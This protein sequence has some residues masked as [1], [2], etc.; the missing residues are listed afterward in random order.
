MFSSH[1]LTAWDADGAVQQMYDVLN[2]LVNVCVEAGDILI[3]G[4]DFNACIGSIDCDDLT[5]L[6]HVG[7]IGMG[8]RNARG[9]M[10][11][12]SILQNKFYVSKSR[13]KSYG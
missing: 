8:Q 13:E 3:V 5:F 6:Q 4:G 12:H 7:P 9:T 1:F 10:L 2:L 11:I